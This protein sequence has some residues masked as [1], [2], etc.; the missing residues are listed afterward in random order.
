[1]TRTPP[2]TVTPVRLWRWRR[3]PLRRHSDVV[4]AWIVLAGWVLALVAGVFAGM[5]AARA[6]DAAFEAR[7][8]QLHPVA[9]VL[10]ADAARTPLAGSGYDDGRVWAVVRWTDADGS[11]HTDRA[12]VPPGAPAGTRMTVWTN[13]ADRVVPAPVTGAA[14]DLQSALTGALVAPAAGALV[15]GVGRLVRGRLIRRRMDEWDAEWRQI[16]P[17]WGNLSGGRG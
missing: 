13:E 12:K 16:G 17:R 15:W 10:T 6:S 5:L 2:T 4:E 7:R 14:A 9:A 11:V 3:N 8:A 1:M